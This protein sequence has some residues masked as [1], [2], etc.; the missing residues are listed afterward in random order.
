M[1]LFSHHYQHQG[2]GPTESGAA[3]PS[4]PSSPIVY[5][6]EI[7][8]ATANGTTGTTIAWSGSKTIGSN[9]DSLLWVGVL[10]YETGGAVTV[11][12]NLGNTY[13]EAEATTQ[14]AAFCN[15]FYAYVGSGTLTSVTATIPTSRYRGIIIAEFYN[16]GEFVEA[17]AATSGSGSPQTWVNSKGI[18]AYGAALGITVSNA[19]NMTGAGSASGT[20]S[21]TITA[22]VI[23]NPDRGLML[24][25][26][27]AGSSA[28]TAFSGTSVVGAGS[29]GNAGAIFEAAA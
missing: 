7:G 14:A 11:A 22:H 8:S 2:R 17:G 18:S 9:A 29:M 26:A 25:S 19:N 20:P 27:I 23:A 15:G 24:L 6:Q 1:S 12:D 5:S 13:T 16:V 4:G 21:T 28:V 10:R 3:P